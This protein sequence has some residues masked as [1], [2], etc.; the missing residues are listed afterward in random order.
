MQS[1][2]C[3]ILAGAQWKALSKLSLCTDFWMQMRIILRIWVASTCRRQIGLNWKL[4]IWGLMEL[5]RKDVNILLSFK[6]I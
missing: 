5:A 4:W 1:E 2:G 3:K 6:E